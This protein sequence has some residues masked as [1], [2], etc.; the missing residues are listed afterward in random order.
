MKKTYQDIAA[1]LSLSVKTVY[2]V[3]NRAP[4]VRPETRDRVVAALN[5]YGFFDA[6]RI[7]KEKVI[8]EF[9]LRLQFQ[10]LQ[11]ERQWFCFI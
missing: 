10:K 3:L 4:N 11:T 9:M 2:R 7:G 5:H 8:I 6:A 1:E